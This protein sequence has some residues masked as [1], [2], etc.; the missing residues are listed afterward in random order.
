MNIQPKGKDMWSGIIVSCENPLLED[1]DPA[2]GDSPQIGRRGL[3]P[4]GGDEALQGVLPY[5]PDPPTAE[6]GHHP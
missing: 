2:G 6:P 5:D 1:I 4:Q 3:S